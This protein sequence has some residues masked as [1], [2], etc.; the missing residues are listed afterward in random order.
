VLLCLV[1]NRF[2]WEP[3]ASSHNS[4][5]NTLSAGEQNPKF[6]GDIIHC[7]DKQALATDNS[8]RLLKCLTT[9]RKPITDKQ[10]K[11]EYT[12]CPTLR[13]TRHEATASYS[14]LQ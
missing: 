11:G 1:C 13:G 3:Y 2:Y 4:T 14:V 5:A 10:W 7:L 6:K 12:V 8:K 9:A